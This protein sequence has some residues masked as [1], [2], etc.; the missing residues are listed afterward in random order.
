V[1]TD[2]AENS[3]SREITYSMAHDRRDHSGKSDGSSLFGRDPPVAHFK[4]RKWCA[5]EERS[6][7]EILQVVADVR[8]ARV[9]LADTKAAL[10]PR[11]LA[12]HGITF[13]A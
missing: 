12:C 11:H 2:L 13:R 7:M 6:R 10:P 3:D 4:I 1:A 5:I 9:N 8:F